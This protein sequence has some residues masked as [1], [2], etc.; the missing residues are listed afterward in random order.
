MN[1]LEKPEVPFE[2]FDVMLTSDDDR[3]LWRAVLT[4]ITDEFL[5][6]YELEPTNKNWVLV[7]GACS[8]WV[9]PNQNRWIA[10][11][12]FADPEGYKDSL[13]ELDW[14]VILHFRNRNWIPIKKLP[15][16]RT[17]IF[18]IAIPAHTARH[19][20]AAVR[21]N[22]TPEKETILYGFR[23]TDGNWE[24]V[25]ASDQKLRGHISIRPEN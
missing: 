12:G 14:S 23:N 24:C 17:R 20:Q 10:A 18:R 7:V 15:G 5:Q 8:H 4:V 22:W 9:R 13:P 21:A 1:T 11:G 2:F 6:R 3:N 19:K 16:K 25:A